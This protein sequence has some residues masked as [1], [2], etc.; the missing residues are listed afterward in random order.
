MLSC[1]V[2]SVEGTRK[3]CLM[4]SLTDLP[5]LMV[6]NVLDKLLIEIVES[7]FNRLEHVLQILVVL[8]NLHCSLT[9]VSAL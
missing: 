7:I 2:L 8:F 6:Y 1:P 3:T 9:T 5:G 4:T